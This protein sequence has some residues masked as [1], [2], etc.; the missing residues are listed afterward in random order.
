MDDGFKFSYH[1]SFSVI[2]EKGVSKTVAMHTRFVRTVGTWIRATDNPDNLFNDEIYN[3][4]VDTL[5]LYKNN[6]IMETG[7]HRGEYMGY[8]SPAIMA[9]VRSCRVDEKNI[10]RSCWIEI[11]SM[12]D[13]ENEKGS[14][15]FVQ[16]NQ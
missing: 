8:I 6:I 13:R 14:R 15:G 3:F 10:Y 1:A 5:R 4:V 2:D 9:F 11:S 16:I 7:F 12:V